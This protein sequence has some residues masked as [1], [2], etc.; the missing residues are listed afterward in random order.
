MRLESSLLF[1]AALI[2]PLPGI[3]QSPAGLPGYEL[4]GIKLGVTFKDAMIA[5]KAHN[6]NMRLQ[7][8]SAPYPGL[9]RPLT[10]GINAVGTGEG[11]YFMLTMPPGE[12]R[13]SKITWVVHFGQDNTP[14]QEV[15]AANLAKQFGRISMDTLPVSL[16][17]G[18]R[19]LYWVDDA[20]GNRV[21]G[22]QIPKRCRAESSFYLTG[23]TPG[24]RP[25]FDPT[26]VHL[27]VMAARLRIEQ[28]YTNK[29]DP[30]AEECGDYTMVRAR[31]FKTM[32]MGVNVPNRV[33]YLVVMIASGPLDRSA[34]K[35]THQYWM[36]T[37]T[38]ARAGGKQ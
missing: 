37:A 10:Y 35:A 13:V 27:P 18:S 12:P 7:D 8:E 23:V 6:P 14:Q 31:L 30:H 21:V 22:E 2:G 16:G 19:D 36:N 25:R 1:V 3:A 32:F 11:F 17:I 26:R 38:A 34:T 24:N 33:E 20:Q 28:G 5:L 15:L 4:A 29:E 9:P